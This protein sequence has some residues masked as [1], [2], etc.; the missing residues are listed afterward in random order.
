MIQHTTQ[1]TRTETLDWRIGTCC[2]F[3]HESLKHLNFKASTKSQALKDPE[4][5]IEK[6]M[7]NTNRLID[8]MVHFSKEPPP[9]R[10]FRIRSDIWPCYTVPEMSG[11]YRDIESE[12]LDGL[13]KSKEI[14]TRYAIRLS[15]HP[16]QF[17]VLGSKNPTVVKNSLSELEYHAKIGAALV[18]NPKDFV[19][20]IHLQGTY[21][22]SHVE[23]IKRF[24]T[25]FL[26]LSS[27]CKQALTVENEDYLS[28]YDV[29]HVL[30]LA[31]IIPVRACVD[32]HHYESYHNGEKVLTIDDTLIHQS[33]QTWQGVRPLFHVSQPVKGSA[34]LAPHSDM[35]WDHT[36]NTRYAQFLKYVDLD[37]EAKAKEVAVKGF[38]T[39]MNNSNYRL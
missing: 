25:H 7:H 6:A 2:Q 37:I 39:W 23:G 22:G 16:D 10:L 27:F 8:I 34:K 4:R 36:R 1:N 31:S 3:S 30:E 9:L 14:A 18:D 38:Y 29:A 33:I 15:M 28:G 35:F 17:C 19:I 21:G 20:N 32:M 5:C 24:S 12:L 26:E 11:Y 13:S